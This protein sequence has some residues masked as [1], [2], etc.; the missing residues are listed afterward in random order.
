MTRFEVT[1]STDGSCSGNPGPGGYAAI[2]RFGEHS[3]EI[4]G[5]SD[6]TTNNRMELQ[7]V[8]EA[9]RTLKHPCNVTIR[10]DSRYVCTGIA[11]AKEWC[12][13]GWKTKSGAKCANA[14]MWKVLADIRSA[15]DHRLRYEYV[16]GHSGDPDN[17]R[18]DKLAK[19][20]VKLVKV[21]VQ[22]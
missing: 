14:D 11:N 17:E 10:T 6:R 7:A 20:Q 4:V 15:G 5:N 22:P 9:V 12:A 16:E 2:L 8:I 19:E 1:I 13:N 3:K 18:C 21:G